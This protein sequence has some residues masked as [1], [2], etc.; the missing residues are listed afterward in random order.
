M[1]GWNGG[2][3]ELD[4]VGLEVVERGWNGVGCSEHGVVMGRWDK[5]NEQ[6]S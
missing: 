4:G 5:E 3:E 2:Q 6:G 1:V